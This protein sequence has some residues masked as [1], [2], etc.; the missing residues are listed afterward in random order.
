VKAP[1]LLLGAL[2]PHWLKLAKP[3]HIRIRQFSD[4]DGLIFQCPSCF[5]RN[6]GSKCVHS[7]IVWRG[8]VPLGDPAMGE[9]RWLFRGTGMGD[10]TLATKTI[11]VDSCGAHFA[12]RE[13]RVIFQ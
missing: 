5:I 11:K 12:V 6:G 8:H 10:L 13:G 7:I 3:E 9:A 2:D 4:A 1:Q